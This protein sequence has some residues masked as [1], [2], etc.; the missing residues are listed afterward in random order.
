MNDTDRKEVLREARQLANSQQYAAAL[1]KYIWFHDHALE[2]DQHMAGVRL[3]YAI[4]EWVELG[5][6]YPPARKALEGV[7]EAKTEALLQGIHDANLFHDV[8]SINDAFGQS[9]RTATLFN[10]IAS[11]NREAAVEC[12]RIALDSLIHTKDF[13][14]ARSFL[15]DPRKEIDQLATPLRIG[16][17]RKPAVDP[18]MFQETLVTIYVKQV[19]LI[20]SAFIG[21][22]E[23]REANCLRDYAIQCVPD[24]QLRERITERL[25]PSSP[26]KQIQ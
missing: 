22:D 15:V 19:G 4:S 1:R 16:I 20:L 11:S 24:A 5:E 23:E 14:L 25:Y 12:F 8:A 13:V 10:S 17:Q 21:A 2:Y 6:V 9:E 18:E 26:S 7:R 3:S